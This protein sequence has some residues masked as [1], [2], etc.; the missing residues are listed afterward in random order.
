MIYTTLKSQEEVKKESE[1]DYLMYFN[2]VSKSETT[3][4]YS[5][6][7]TDLD[8][9]MRVMSGCEQFRSLPARIPSETVAKLLGFEKHEITVLV[10]SKLLK[11]L[12]KP[13][14]NGPKRF[15]KIEIF[16]LAFDSDW[17]SQATKAIT[18]NWKAKNSRK[19][20]L[21]EP[22]QALAA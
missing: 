17:L 20:A 15:A 9:E 2:V 8:L 6:E 14:P 10:S 1:M 21:L 4:N 18:A 13:A 7:K 3:D 12:G 11:P 19:T 5:M 22:N 16:R